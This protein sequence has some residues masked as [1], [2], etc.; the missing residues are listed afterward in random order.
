MVEDMILYAISSQLPLKLLPQIGGKN[1]NEYKNWVFP[2]IRKYATSEKDK[3]TGAIR[4]E[5][6][7]EDRSS[8]ILYIDSPCF[9]RNIATCRNFA[10][11]RILPGMFLQPCI[12]KLPSNQLNFSKGKSIVATQLLQEWNNFKS[13]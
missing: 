12:E 8:S 4:W 6:S 1:S 11:L 2:I 10:E 3:G 7:I 13:C 5:V 9:T